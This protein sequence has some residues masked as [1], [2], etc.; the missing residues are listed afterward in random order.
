MRFLPFDLSFY[1]IWRKQ[2][3]LHPQESSRDQSWLHWMEYQL[4]N[5]ILR[6]SFLSSIQSLREKFQFLFLTKVIVFQISH[7]HHQDIRN[8]RQKHNKMIF[9]YDRLSH[10]KSPHHDSWWSMHCR[11][12]TNQRSLFLDEFRSQNYDVG[13]VRNVEIR[14]QGWKKNLRST[15]PDIFTENSAVNFIFVKMLS[16]ILV[17]ISWRYSGS[18]ATNI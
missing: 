16:F 10:K 5:P 18:L 12:F 14:F 6:H 7:C 17:K 9:L 2:V 3:P 15:F 8:S 4:T 1:V 11:W 13:S